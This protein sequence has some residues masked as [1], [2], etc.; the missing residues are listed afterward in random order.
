MIYKGLFHDTY[1]FYLERPAA[2][3]DHQ[4]ARWEAG[5]QAARSPAGNP[6]SARSVSLAARAAAASAA[7]S[8]QQRQASIAQARAGPPTIPARL[9]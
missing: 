3:R 6:G 9:H 8:S 7:V 5:H 1:F 4:E 2:R